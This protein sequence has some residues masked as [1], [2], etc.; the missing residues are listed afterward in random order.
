M[1]EEELIK[2]VKIQRKPRGKGFRATIPI[3][4]SQKL[5][6]KGKEKAKVLF[7]KKRRRIIYEI[8]S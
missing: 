4:A 3:E 6:I 7:E 8:I 2:I 5:G 1:S